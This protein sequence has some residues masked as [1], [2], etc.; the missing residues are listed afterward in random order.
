MKTD[1]QEKNWMKHYVTNQ[2]TDPKNI[3]KIENVTTTTVRSE[4]GDPN[5]SMEQNHKKNQNWTHYNSKIKEQKKPENRNET[6]EEYPGKTER[7][8]ERIKK[9]L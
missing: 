6:F 1:E 9:T 2:K 7:R 4:I 5:P 3:G 8:P